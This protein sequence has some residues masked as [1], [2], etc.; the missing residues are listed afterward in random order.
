M[1][2]I[3]VLPSSYGRTTIFVVVGRLSKICL[4]QNH[5]I[6]TQQFYYCDLFN[7]HHLLVWFKQNQ[8]TQFEAL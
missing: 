1:D 8:C 6:G 2:F 3:D 7:L 5:V 4:R